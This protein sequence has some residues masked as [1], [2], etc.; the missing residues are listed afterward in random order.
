MSTLGDPVILPAD[1]ME[2]MA[3][4]FKDYG[5]RVEEHEEI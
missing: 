5:K 4:R 2:R 3:E 1:E